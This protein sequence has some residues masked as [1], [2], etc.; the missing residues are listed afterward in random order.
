MESKFQLTGL[1]QYVCISVSHFR[2]V[3]NSNYCLIDK[4]LD[5]QLEFQTE[6]NSFCEWGHDEGGQ[7]RF[8][9]F[10]TPEGKVIN[11]FSGKCLTAEYPGKATFQ[12]CD[13]SSNSQMWWYDSETLQFHYKATDQATGNMTTYCLDSHGPIPSAVPW[14]RVEWFLTPDCTPRDWVEYIV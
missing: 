3:F 6:G 8:N 14:S 9:F 5:T 10:I 12:K 4:S 7:S 13:E 1:Q 11:A 2:H